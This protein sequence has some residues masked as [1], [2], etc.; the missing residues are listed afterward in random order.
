MI[1]A[2]ADYGDCYT[3]TAIDPDTKLMPCWL[4]GSRT[5]EC[6]D[7]FM[8][9]LAPRMANRI[10]LTTDSLQGLCGCRGKGIPWQRGLR[11]AEQ[12]LQPRLPRQ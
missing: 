10:Q 5:A 1:V 12:D 2:H 8:A 4:V 9:D 11:D 6:A 3:F 7:E